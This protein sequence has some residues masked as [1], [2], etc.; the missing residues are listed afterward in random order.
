MPTRSQRSRPFLVAGFMAAASFALAAVPAAAETYD[1]ERYLNIRNSS[2]AGLSPDAKSV[3]F[4]TSITG[5]NQIWIVPAAGGWPQPIT[6]F[7]DRVSGVSWS[8]RGDLI[9]YSK[10]TGGDENFQLH[11][12]TP[13]GAR[14][15]ALTSDAKVRHNFGGWS[16][17]GKLIGYSSN[18]RNPKF[19]DVYVM[20]IETKQRR[21]IVEKDALFSAGPFSD[22]GARIIVG[23]SNASLDNDLFV[24]DLAGGLSGGPVEPVLLT[25]HEGIAAFSATGWSPDGRFLWIVSD[26]GREFFALG[27]MEISSKTITWEREP[28]WDVGGARLSEDGR[29]L[30]VTVNVDGFDTLSIIDTATMKDRPAPAVPRGQ[31]ENMVFSKDAK[32]LAMTLT[33]GARNGDVWLADLAGGTMARVTRSSTAGIPADSF[34]EPRLVRHRTFD[35]LE[36]PALFYLP[37]GAKKGDALPCIVN[38]HGGPEGQ[39]VSRFSAVTQY[40]VNRGYAVWAPNV[41]GSTGYGKTFTHLDDVRKREDSVK[42]LV[43]GVD[44]LK[45]SGWIDPDK[46]AVMGGSYGGYMTLAAVTLYPDLWAAAVN[47]FGIANFRTFFGKTASYRVSLRASEYG[48][49]E[50]DGEFFDSISPIH[51]VD[52]I[53]TPL[54][55]LQGAN[56]PRVPA[57]E[58]EQIVEAIRKRGGTAEYVLFN[59]EGHGWTKLANQ[60]TAHRATAAFL[61]KHVKGAAPKGREGS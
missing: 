59:D 32:T 16:K 20:D 15:I 6:F 2:V 54:L 25:P 44:W 22:D 34:E 9:A 13:D 33:S 45:S 18:E 19:F 27:R 3:A 42:D 5:S 53:T 1:I 50:K 37:K 10:D 29:T 14:Q 12:V 4:L 31:I 41:R 36:I 17:D 24:A 40:Y 26:R 58:S 43:A 49:P 46:I 57:H 47:S 35:G 39:T 52:R 11:L 21:R 60:I 51:K 8:P 56:D 38:P 28:K 30:A 48:D 7:A 61:D 55:V 23:R